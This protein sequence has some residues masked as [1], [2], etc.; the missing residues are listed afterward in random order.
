MKH[1]KNCEGSNRNNDG[2]NEDDYDD[3]AGLK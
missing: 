2:F 1:N 3:D